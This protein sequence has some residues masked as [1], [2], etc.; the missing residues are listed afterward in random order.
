MRA[1]YQSLQK[2]LDLRD[3]YMQTSKQRLG[4]NP[5][6]Y[7]EV[8]VGLDESVCGPSGVRPDAEWSAKLDGKPED[9]N[10]FEPWKIY[11][12]P[13]PPHWHWKDDEPSALDPLKT[14]QIKAEFDFSK[15]YIPE[16]DSR[17][18]SIDDRGVYQ[19]YDGTNAGK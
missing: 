2:C 17:E 13:P 18:F 1:M 9:T 10:E 12:P 15:C 4:D 3:K 8:F 6:D 5:R 11:P 14:G 16:P 19:V 7:D